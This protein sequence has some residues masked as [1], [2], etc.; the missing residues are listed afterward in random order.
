MEDSPARVGSN[1]GVARGSP[2]APSEPMR[3]TL[4][5]IVPFTSD[6]PTGPL[7]QR[8]RT[9]MIRARLVWNGEEAACGPQHGGPAA[10][11]HKVTLARDPRSLT[12]PLGAQTRRLNAG[13]CTTLQLADGTLSEVLE[14]RPDTPY[15]AVSDGWAALSQPVELIST[16]YVN[17]TNQPKPGQSPD[18]PH[19]G[20]RTFSGLSNPTVRTTQCPGF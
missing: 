6:A 14:W 10:P 9:D 8:F 4:L 17:P 15:V 5:S 13:G 7:H 11:I 18:E 16:G 1:P 2:K 12:F 19:E 3:R 20:E